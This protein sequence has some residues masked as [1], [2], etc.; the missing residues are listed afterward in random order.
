EGVPIT[1]GPDEVP[2]GIARIGGPYDTVVDFSAIH[3]AVIDTGVDSTHPDLNVVSG[4]DAD[5]VCNSGGDCADGGDPQGHGTHVAGTIGAAAD[6]S[7]VVGVAP[8]VPIHDVRVLGA[9]GSGYVSDILA[10]IEYVLDNPEIRV[11]NMSLGGPAGS[12]LDGELDEAI[13]RM[14]DAGVV[15]SIAAGNEAQ[16]TRNVVPAGL[17]RGIV[18][19]AYDASAG[20]NGWA[21]F[22]NYGDAV[23][24]AAPG[25]GIVST[26]PGGDV[27]ALDGTSMAAPHVA[28]A[29]AVY[30]ALHP[31]K[32]PGQVRSAIVSTAENGL[33]GQGGDHPEGMLDLAALTR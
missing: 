22:S 29:A 14:E 9:D 15:V 30:L 21:F 31:D 12:A 10:G 8:G 32:G 7:G 5:M 28:G 25:V 6:G 33:A 23:D 27:A 11:V 26:W 3:V 18:V 13:R 16:D 20:D 2:A 1:L 19:S 17:D 4:R 24:I